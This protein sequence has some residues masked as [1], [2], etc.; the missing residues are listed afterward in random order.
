MLRNYHGLKGAVSVPRNLH[1]NCVVVF[2]N[3]L[4]GS[5]AVPAVAGIISCIV[6]FLVAQMRIHFCIKSPRIKTACGLL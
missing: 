6:I 1:L 3:D 4:F 5:V 2:K